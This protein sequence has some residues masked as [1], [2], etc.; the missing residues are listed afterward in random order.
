MSAQEGPAKLVKGTGPQAG[1]TRYAVIGKVT[2]NDGTYDTVNGV[3]MNDDG[4]SW[5]SHSG[6][7]F[8]AADQVAPT[9]ED[10]FTAA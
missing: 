6:R 1:D 7:K 3:A 8:V 9:G 4:S 2:G 10:Y 5:S